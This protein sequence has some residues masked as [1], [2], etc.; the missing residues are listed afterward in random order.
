MNQELF[1]N[2][3][4]SW[5][6]KAARELVIFIYH[7]GSTLSRSVYQPSTFS[8]QVKG[9]V[10]AATK[11]FNLDSLSSSFSNLHQGIIFFISHPFMYPL[12]RASLLP[13]ILLSIVVLFNLFLFA[14]LPQVAFLAI[15]QGWS[16]WLNGTILVLGEGAAIVAVLYECFFADETQ[17]DIFD[18]V[19]MLFESLS[20]S[21]AFSVQITHTCSDQ[22]WNRWLTCLCHVK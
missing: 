2:T 5:E 8:M 21:P 19:R 7:H 11:N 15:F 3:T 12:F 1:K 9:M 18:A 22:Q 16:A 20:A 4:V 6:V 17:V 14:Y 13:C 10:S